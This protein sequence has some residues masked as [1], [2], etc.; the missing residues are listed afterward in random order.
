MKPE[1][2]YEFK[3]PD[4]K[5]KRHWGIISGIALG[6]AL[7]A[8]LLV[9]IVAQYYF[10]ILKF[11]SIDPTE[12]QKIGNWEFPD[13]NYIATGIGQITVDN[14]IIAMSEVMDKK[15]GN[16]FMFFKATFSENGFLRAKEDLLNKI[17]ENYNLNDFYIKASDKIEK[18]GEEISYSAVGWGKDKNVR[19]G[20]IA[21]IDCRGKSGNIN[22]VFAGAINTISKYDNGRALEFIGTLKCDS[23]D[24]GISGEERNIDKL[25]SDKDGLTDKVEIM[26]KADPYKADTDGDGYNDFN[27]IKNG[28]S[29]MA[30][31]PWDKYTPEEFAKVKKDIK[32][33][34]EDVYRVLFGEN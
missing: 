1:Q 8:V 20:I 4:S 34:N 6:L 5:K 31:R 21:S 12:A 23:E 2:M 32:Y 26:L 11:K 14:R 13:G 24:K 22:T 19:G 17:L 25:D 28:F 15:S 10:N 3:K 16:K 29:P 27:E 7:T 30:L 33:V 18:Y 9:L